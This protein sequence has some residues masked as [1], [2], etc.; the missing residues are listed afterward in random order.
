MILVI[1]LFL[2]YFYRTELLFQFEKF[3]LCELILKNQLIEMQKDS[4]KT[5]PAN[6]NIC[7]DLYFDLLIKQQHD[8][9][10]I[11]KELEIIKEE[12]KKKV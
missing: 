2:I 12:I 3:D 7:I 10:F 6:L 11:H 8:S 9:T 1:W 4:L 5:N